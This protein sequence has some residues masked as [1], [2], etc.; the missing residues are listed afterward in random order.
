VRLGF[1]QC[2]WKT[3]AN[4]ALWIAEE[5]AG[6]GNPEH[7]S[8]SETQARAKKE[9]CPIEAHQEGMQ[10]SHCQRKP[11]PEPGEPLDSRQRLQPHFVQLLLA[12]PFGVVQT[13]YSARDDVSARP[14]SRHGGP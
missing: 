1:C 11:K 8:A 10:D 12:D 14:S 3:E 5:Q 7:G 9:Q 13:D 4:E 6:D 2:A